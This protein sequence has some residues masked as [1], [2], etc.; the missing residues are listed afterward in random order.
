MPA[1]PTASGGR[2]LP[3]GGRALV[4]LVGLVGL[5]VGLAGCR[6][7]PLQKENERCGGDF[8]GCA[9]GLRCSF[10]K[11]RCYRPVDCAL[12]ERRTKACLVE[13]VSVYAPKMAKLPAPKRTRLL[14]RIG[15]HLKTEML[16]H[17]K[18][19]AAAWQKKHATAPTKTKSYG[20]DPRAKEVVACLHKQ[21]CRPFATC[22]LGLARV[23]GPKRPNPRDPPVFP[24]A[25]PRPAPE[26]KPD[27][28]PPPSGADAMKPDQKAAPDKKPTPDKK[29]AP[30]KRPAPVK[31]AAPDKRPAPVKKP[32]RDAMEPFERP[33]ASRPTPPPR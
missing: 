8:G 13:L 29:A 31:M 19:D 9:K 33:M 6:D 24:I 3:P 20:E 1:H 10:K 14:E 22:L 15:Q 26:A 21:G 11:K 16:D 23:V 32:V 27:A 4:A 5:V 7:L 12:L 30:D 2:R 25:P 28:D 17:C 18:Y